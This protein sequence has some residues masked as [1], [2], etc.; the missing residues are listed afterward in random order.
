MPV[1]T[2]RKKNPKKRNSVSCPNAKDFTFCLGRC[3]ARFRC[4][5]PNLDSEMQGRKKLRTKKF[6]KHE[7]ELWFHEKQ[8]ERDLRRSHSDRGL[9]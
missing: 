2:H 8:A 9:N 3:K 1:Q 4:D 5:L 7:Q 6:R